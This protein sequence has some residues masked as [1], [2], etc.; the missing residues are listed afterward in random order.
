MATIVYLDAEDEIT[1]AA[2]RIRAATDS[3]VGLVIPFGSRVA[4]SR[5]NFRLLARE[6]MSHGRRL[7][8]VAPD[9]SARA[10]AASAGL[11]VFASVGEYEEALDDDDAQADARRADARAAAGITVAGAGA[12]ATDPRATRSTDP[13]PASTAALA[14]GVAGAAGAAGAATKGGAVGTKAGTAP[15]PDRG[16]DAYDDA[17]AGQGRG[18][19]LPVVHGRSRRRPIGIA[20]GALL[21]IAIAGG[22]AAFAGYLLLPHAAITVTPKVEAVGPVDFSVT[23]DPDATSVDEA[24]GVIPAVS[25]QV[26]VEAQG[27]FQ[28]T[29]KRVERTPAT[30]AVRWTNCDPTAPYS[31]AS[32]SVV[33]TA[34]GIAFTTDETVFLP[35][36]ILSGGGSSPTLQCQT[37]EVAVTAVVPG[38]SGNVP[39]GAIR[40]VPA[41]YNR[42]V[43]RVNNPQPTT[44]G[45]REEFTRI[46]QQ[47]VDA[48]MAQL[49]KDLE[50]TFA[51]DAANPPGVPAT[52]T[53]FEET[54][55]LGDPVPSVDPKTLVGQEVDSFTLHVTADGTVLAADASPA[56]AIAADRL[57]ASVKQ[58]YQMA[59]D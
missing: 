32:G 33:R 5:I 16:Y 36:A 9:A 11:P 22:A 31:I 46:S 20:I 45:K 19:S 49:G 50:A 17:Q 1:S 43:V 39:A 24:A 3:R 4:T 10:L 12:D 52:M 59:P 21:I 42:N 58:G 13:R 7:D 41:R 53:V 28:A 26:P 57:K 15:S 44:G 51:T 29:G 48:A 2:S 37:S 34:A 25:V 23:A 56:E 54:A 8:I 40:V 35:V 14:A 55:V 47:D 18:S 38:P 6:A 27:E 30:G